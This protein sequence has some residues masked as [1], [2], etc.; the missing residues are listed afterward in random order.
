METSVKKFYNQT[1]F[2]SNKQFDAHYK[3]Y[4]GYIEKIDEVTDKL[5]NFT[6]RPDANATYSE[7]RGLKKGE[8]YAANGVI[9]HEQYFQLLGAGN[10]QPGEKTARILNEQFGGY[11]NWRADFLASGLS[12][13][14]WVV[15]LYD[16]RTRMYRNVVLDFHDQGYICGG[17]PLIVMDMYEHAYFIDFATDKT[18]YINGFTDAIRWDVVEKS[19][20]A[21]QS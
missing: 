10:M 11:D 4:T 9:L 14:G 1:H 19:A 16:Q 6:G 20:E 5:A 15:F 21:I 13:R 18:S 2:L 8:T 7:Y 3:L 12:A 17:Y